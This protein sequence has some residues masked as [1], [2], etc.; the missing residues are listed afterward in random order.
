MPTKNREAHSCLKGPVVADPV[1][2]AGDVPAVG[3]GAVEVVGWGAVAFWGK[4]ESARSFHVMEAATASM[5]GSVAPSIS[6]SAPP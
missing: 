3:A 1:T 6:A 5:R 2:A 4:N